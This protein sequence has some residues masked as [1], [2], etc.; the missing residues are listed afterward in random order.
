MQYNFCLDR[1]I[2]CLIILKA[3]TS[4]SL[5]FRR[6]WNDLHCLIKPRFISTSWKSTLIPNTKIGFIQDQI[7]SLLT[8]LYS[9]MQCAC[10]RQKKASNFNSICCCHKNIVN[11]SHLRALPKDFFTVKLPCAT[12]HIKASKQI[13][14]LHSN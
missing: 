14:Q 3:I 12:Y 4:L 1:E 10:I 5:S 11:F 13:Y 9:T 8:S 6:L 7:T 2:T